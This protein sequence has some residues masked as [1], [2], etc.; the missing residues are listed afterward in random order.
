ME[1]N[2]YSDSPDYVFMTIIDHHQEYQ[3]P[4][5]PRINQRTMWN[6]F[7][8]SNV[9]DAYVELFHPEIPFDKPTYQR[10]SDEQLYAVLKRRLF[11]KP[12][13]LPEPIEPITIDDVL[14]TIY[15]IG[16]RLPDLIEWA[17][18]FAIDI[19]RECQSVGGDDSYYDYFPM[20]LEMFYYVCRELNLHDLYIE[21]VMYV[22]TDPS[23]SYHDDDDDTID[24]CWDE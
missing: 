23:S 12:N 15:R 18:T 3:L 7:D 9:I 4:I 14:T 17:N 20:Y 11:T 19:K 24:L 6:G 16:G 2:V 22:M 10:V 5:H 13:D 21:T 8:V 1:T